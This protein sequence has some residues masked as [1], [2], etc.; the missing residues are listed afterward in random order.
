M[1]VLSCLLFPGITE[2]QTS[3]LMERLGLQTQSQ[4]RVLLPAW[5][6]RMSW[7]VLADMR[8]PQDL[9]KSSGMLVVAD[10]H[11]ARNRPWLLRIHKDRCD[12]F[13]FTTDSMR[14]MSCELYG[15]FSLAPFATIGAGSHLEVRL[16]PD[17]GEQ[18]DRELRWRMLPLLSDRN[19]TNY[20]SGPRLGAEDAMEV[21]VYTGSQALLAAQAIRV[22]ANDIV[23]GKILVVAS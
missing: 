22:K 7:Y 12:E 13:G 5:R 15:T 4:S 8:D 6:A 16:T 2:E 18:Y 11:L 1:A 3:Q 14:E 23:I 17:D 20:Y 10:L 19:V 21:S 9:R